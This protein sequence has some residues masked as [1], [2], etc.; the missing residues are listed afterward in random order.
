MSAA[1]AQN[2]LDAVTADFE[3]IGKTL[4]G[5]KDLV[6]VLQSP[7]VKQDAK[8]KILKQIFDGKISKQMM[9]FLVLISQ[10]GRERFIDETVV[11]FKSMLDAK[12]GIVPVEVKSAV[13]LDALQ[14]DALRTKLETF[15]SKKIRITMS[16]DKA[17][18]GGLSVRIGDTVIDGS[19]KH[20]L[21][22]LRERFIGEILN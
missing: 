14:S 17:L 6:A 4:K 5:S 8:E 13:D 12:N 1:E 9:S 3:L 18:I 11:D 22:Q 19:V 16:I 20:K 15:T 21:E 7:V 2:N 10:K